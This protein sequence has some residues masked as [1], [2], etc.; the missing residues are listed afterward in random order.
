MAAD[1]FEAEPI[2]LSA[3]E[4]YS[5][6]PRQCAL[7]HLEQV[8]EENVLTLRGE[9]LHRRVHEVEST[10]SGRVERS[11]PL[12]SERLGLV[13]RADVVEFRD[14]TPYPVEYKHGRINRFKPA[15]L[16]LCGQ[17]ICLEEM[18]GKQVSAG[19]IYWWSS[20]R[21][22]EVQFNNALRKQVADTV[23]AIRSMLEQGTL[24]PP[25]QDN[26][27]SHCSLR[28]SCMPRAVRDRAR[29]RMLAKELFTCRDL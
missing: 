16:Q 29:A 6:C 24:P 3:I 9:F 14:G 12:W 2:L 28:E 10:G 20:R 18:T 4:H 22:F 21:R 7:I 23:T 15:A 17:A 25:V 27:C 11:L 5:Y 19:A 26:R 1:N 8:F 13:G